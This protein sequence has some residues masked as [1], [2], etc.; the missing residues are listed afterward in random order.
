MSYS[1]M[2]QSGEENYV[3]YRKIKARKD[4]PCAYAK[5]SGAQCDGTI[6]VGEEYVDEVLVPW[7]PEWD[8]DE[9]DY[10][11]AK[12][13]QVGV[14][15]HWQHTRYHLVCE[16]TTVEHQWYGTP[17]QQAAEEAA[18]AARAAKEKADRDQAEAWARQHRRDVQQKNSKKARRE[19]EIAAHAGAIILDDHR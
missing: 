3:S 9:D 2:P 11:R 7:T 15:G 18:E 14:L 4:W 8:A 19:R 1:D 17:E 6:R 12:A 16:R 5:A 10:G 13:V